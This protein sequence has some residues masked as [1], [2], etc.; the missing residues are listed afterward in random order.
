LLRNFYA[1]PHAFNSSIVPMAAGFRADSGQSEPILA[2]AAELE[3][4]QYGR[5]D[6]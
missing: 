5:N 6:D 4:A 1:W 2:P 3:V